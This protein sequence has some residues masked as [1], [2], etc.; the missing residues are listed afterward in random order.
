MQPMIH[1]RKKPNTLQ[2]SCL[3]GL[4]KVQAPYQPPASRL[5]QFRTPPSPR[6]FK[7]LSAAGDGMCCCALLRQSLEQCRHDREIGRDPG[8]VESLAMVGEA[9]PAEF[10]VVFERPGI[11]LRHFSEPD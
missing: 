6:C 10:V 2:V 1:G 8:K 5:P 9:D 3:P 11:T 7:G 4:P